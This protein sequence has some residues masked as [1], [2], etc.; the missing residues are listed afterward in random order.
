MTIEETAQL[1]Y[2]AANRQG[3]PMSIDVATTIAKA[4]VS[5]HLPLDL[6]AGY[7]AQNLRERYEER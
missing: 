4:L 3:T 2:D 6:P 1:I 7:V 5:D